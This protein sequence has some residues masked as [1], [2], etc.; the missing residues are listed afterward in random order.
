MSR[1]YGR[2]LHSVAYVSDK[3]WRIPIR[4]MFATELK[5]IISNTYRDN[6]DNKTSSVI[7]T[8]WIPFFNDEYR[9]NYIIA[10][11]NLT[12]IEGYCGVAT[13]KIRALSQFNEEECEKISLIFEHIMGS[14]LLFETDDSLHKALKKVRELDLFFT[15]LLMISLEGCVLEYPFMR[16]NWKYEEESFKEIDFWKTEEDECCED[17]TV[18]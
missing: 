14:C 4:K 13:S 12:V 16:P 3:K 7:I 8:D 1:L 11:S 9:V 6:L 15:R 18:S 2:P 17:L 10:R 5:S